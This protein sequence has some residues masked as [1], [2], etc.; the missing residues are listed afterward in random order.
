MTLLSLKSSAKLSLNLGQIAVFCTLLLVAVFLDLVTFPHTLEDAFITFRYSEHLSEG[1]SLGAWNTTGDI[2]EGYSTTLWMLVLALGNYIGISVLTLSKLLGIVCHLTLIT[3]LFFP[4]KSM[5]D[6]FRSETVSQ[7]QEILIFQ[8]C[9]AMYAL[10]FP[11]SFYA[12]SGMETIA[13]VFLSMYML[14]IPY[15][16]RLTVSLSIAAACLVLLRPEGILVAI[17]CGVFH[18]LRFHINHQDSRPVLTALGVSIVTFLALTIFRLLYYD[19]LFPNTYYAKMAEGGVN[20]LWLGTKYVG[21]WVLMH[22]PMV[23]VLVPIA[24]LELRKVFR[25]RQFLKSRQPLMPVFLVLFALAYTFYV[26]RSGGDEWN[27]FPY[28]RHLIH[29]TPFLFLIFAY[30]LS[31]YLFRSRYFGYSFF[32]LNLIL[33]NVA[34]VL[35]PAG[36]VNWLFSP[37]PA[38]LRHRPPSEFVRWFGRYADDD[39]VI[40]SAAAGQIPYYT[41]AIHIDILGLNDPYIARHG[42]YDPLGSVDSKT[43]MDYVLSQQPDIME[44]PLKI[45]QV[46]TGFGVNVARRNIIYST[47]DNPVF[48][49]NYCFVVNGPYQAWNRA[50]FMKTSYIEK[51]N[52][53]E[54]DC[55]PVRQTAIYEF[56]E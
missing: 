23:G 52:F 39:T 32:A 1:Y 51:R 50:I 10:Y 48:A 41:D 15:P 2:V 11:I 56:Y 27:A 33:L 22:P 9:S 49:E 5:Q 31:K 38:L 28:W 37:S 14:V 35:S 3:L 17:A 30:G 29:L 25:F 26:I 53:D 42:A 36:N 20:H 55:I 12:T 54:I 47:L 21:R 13:F 19:S 18:V 8:L 44:L 46:A 4:T 6:L 24:V 7:K 34:A 40:A 16:K 43:D 45:E